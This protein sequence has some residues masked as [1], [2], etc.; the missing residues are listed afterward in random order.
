MINTNHLKETKNTW[1]S[2]FTFAFPE[3]L[4]AFGISIV[5][6]LHSIIP[7]IFYNG[8]F[9]RYIRNALVRLDADQNRWKEK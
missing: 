9:D 5:M 8:H 7:F 3:A 4:Y 2:H 6:L 1:W